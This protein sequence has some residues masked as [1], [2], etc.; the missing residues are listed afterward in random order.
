MKKIVIK[1]TVK[2]IELQDINT[3]NMLFAYRQRSNEHVSYAQLMKLPNHK[4]AF[5]SSR[6]PEAKATFE[7][8][9]PHEAIEKC[10]KAGRNIFAF[11]SVVKMLKAMANQEF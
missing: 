2:E 1:Q 7:A 10:V 11:D 9:T 5:K 3:D 6:Y 8:S 4:F